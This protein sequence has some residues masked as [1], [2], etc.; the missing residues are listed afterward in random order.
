M[1][2][3]L[4][5]GAAEFLM[6]FVLLN[7]YFYVVYCYWLFALFRSVIALFC[8]SSILLWYLRTFLS[9][10]ISIPYILIQ[11]CFSKKTKGDKLNKQYRLLNVTYS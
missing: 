9:R 3:E 4:L 8:P 10:I 1:E 11:T 2:Q 6:G 7:V 5:T